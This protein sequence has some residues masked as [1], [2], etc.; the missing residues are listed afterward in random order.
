MLCS[1][2]DS[3]GVAGM[4][5]GPRV[6]HEYVLEL[7]GRRD[8]RKKFDALNNDML[9]KFLQNAF[10]RSRTPNGVAGFKL[11]WE[12]VRRLALKL[13]YPAN[14]QRFGFHEFATLVPETT[15]FIWLTRRQRVRQ[16]VSLVKAVQSQCWNSAEQERFKGFYVFDYVA[17][18]KT[19]QMLE[20]HDA[21][22]REFFEHNAIEPLEVVYE[23][24]VHDRRAQLQ[25]IAGFVGFP[26]AVASDIGDNQY[27]QQSEVLN[28]LWVERF[29]HIR[30]LGPGLRSL[31]WALGIPRWLGLRALSKIRAARRV[32]R[33]SREKW[34]ER[35]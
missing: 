2:L 32:R 3:T 27:R 8:Q 35:C 16:A 33:L 28:E 5:P 19:T 11:M 12:Q 25:R 26:F 18:E 29:E 30:A 21:M 31:Y 1:L 23:D 15:C 34:L 14:S 22:W 7:V 6:I 20:E 17:L 10:D 9:R 13:G 24:V 4:R